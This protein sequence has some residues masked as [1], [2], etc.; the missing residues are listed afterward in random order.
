M[1]GRAAGLRAS[2]SAEAAVAFACPRPQT[3]LAMAIAKP[4][5]I[6]T[7]LGPAAAAGSPCASTGTA[8]HITASIRK[9]KLMVF[10]ICVAPLFYELPQWVVDLILVQRPSRCG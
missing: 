7:Q 9:T 2:A 5:V 4:E 10:R 3:A 8:K 6:A 1:P